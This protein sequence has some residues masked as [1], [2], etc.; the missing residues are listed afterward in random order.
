MIP[1][2]YERPAGCR[3]TAI[4]RTVR[5]VADLTGQGLAADRLFFGA[6]HGRACAIDSNGQMEWNPAARDVIRL[7]A[8]ERDPIK[9]TAG[10]TPCA[11]IL[12]RHAA[13]SEVRGIRTQSHQLPPNLNGRPEQGMR[14]IGHANSERCSFECHLTVDQSGLESNINKE[15]TNGA[16]SFMN[17]SIPEK[18]QGATTSSPIKPDHRPCL[19]LRR[20]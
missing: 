3:P 10:T 19:T 13:P 6:A 20:Q 2:G 11:R 8:I 5:Q 4:N 1:R 17:L 18:N 7:A 16:F 9:G 14:V 15:P 12:L